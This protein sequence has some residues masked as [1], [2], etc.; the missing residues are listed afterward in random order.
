MDEAPVGAASYNITPSQAVPAVRVT[1]RRREMV[2]LRWG[3]IPCWA[4]EAKTSYSMINARAETVAEKPAYRSAFRRRR[5]L[6]PADGFFE[7]KQTAQGKQPY[8][9]R[10]KDAGVFALA[11]LWEH[12]EQAGEVID[13]CTIIV[14]AANDTIR[15]VHDRMP[16]IIKPPDYAQWLDPERQDA[17]AASRLLH[18]YPADDM[19]AWPVSTYVNNPANN[20]ARCIAQVT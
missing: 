10:M 15:P 3:L 11:G 6:L 14:T 7:W 19:V 2:L 13:S 18:P 9:M 4:K 8:Y 16:V 12:W 1:Q 20:D 5:C 17:A